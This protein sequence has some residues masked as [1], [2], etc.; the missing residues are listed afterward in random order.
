MKKKIVLITGSLGLVGAESV[1]FFCNKKYEVLG[2]DNDMR[3]YFFGLSVNSNKKYLLSKFSNYSHVNIDI[4]NRNKI[5]KIFKDNKKKIDLVI[6]CAAQPSHDWAAK[7]PH[8][9]F[10]INANGTLNLLKAC[11]E[12]SPKSKFIFM[13]T[14]KVYGDACNNFK[15]KENKTR[16]ILEKRN[17]YSKYG[18]S[19]DFK[20]DQS[21]HSL[22]GVSKCAADLLVQ[23]FGRYYGLKTAIFRGGCLTGPLHQG[24][25]LHGFL[26][27]LLKCNIQNKKY[28]VKGYSGKQVRDNIHSS[29][30]VNAFWEYYKKPRIGE[31]YNIGGGIY[32]NCSIIEAS[33]IISKFSRK[34]THLIFE[35]EN[36]IGD[37]KWW[38]SDV[39]KFKK[40]YP[41]WKLKY[42]IT[43]IIEDMYKFSS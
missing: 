6:H 33:D 42:K 43:D 24:A 13:S 27:Y 15:F 25:E 5:E 1:K 3:K 18:I 36:R 20:I 31:V 41:E 26:S 35:K 2:I 30:L 17:K 23:E 9:D 4:R 8:T 11:L 10:E 37:H 38:I 21:K 7:E 34:K 39:R 19:E 28:Y 40:H 29:D 14:N 12:Y 22:F 32:S 16:F